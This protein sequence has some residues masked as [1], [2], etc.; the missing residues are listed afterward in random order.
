M[1]PLLGLKGSSERAQIDDRLQYHPQVYEFF[2][3]TADFTDQG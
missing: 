2:T 1:L 3:S